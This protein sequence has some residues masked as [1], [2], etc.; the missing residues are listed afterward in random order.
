MKRLFKWAL[1]LFLVVVVLLVAA[2]LLLNTIVKEVVQSR[3]RSETGMDVKIGSLD[4]GL[5]TPTIA[6]ENLKLYNTP[7]FG[8]SPFLDI[9]EIFV[10]YDKDAVRAGKLHLKLLRLN[11]AEIDIVQDKQGRLNIQSLKE[12]GDTATAALNRQSSGFKFTGIDTLNVTLQ[13]MR[14]SNLDAPN[15]AQ[16]VDFGLTNQVFTNITSEA[17]LAGMALVLDLRS[18]TAAPKGKSPIDTQKL[19]QQLLH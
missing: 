4:I 10:E 16:E 8:G 1:Y 13:K 15:Q 17:D 12:K 19:L 11:L 2:V 6:I 9:P 5:S 14:V 7:E 3:L 18:G